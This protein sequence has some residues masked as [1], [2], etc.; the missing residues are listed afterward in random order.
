M[1]ASIVMDEL[2]KIR[3]DNSLRHSRMSDEEISKEHKDA[4]EWF[5]SRLEKPVEIVDTAEIIAKEV[6]NG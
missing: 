3:D 1:K 2:R 6:Q 5:I 4:L